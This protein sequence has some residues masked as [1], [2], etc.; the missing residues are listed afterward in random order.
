VNIIIYL[1]LSLSLEAQSKPSY[2]SGKQICSGIQKKQSGQWT[3][4]PKDYN[5]LSK[6]KTS[7]YHRFLG[8][9]FDAS[10]PTIVRVD[11]GPGSTSHNYGP[12]FDELAKDHNIL[13]FDQRGYVCSRPDQESDQGDINFYGIEKSARDIE[14]IRKA[15]GIKKLIVYGESFGATISTQYAALFPESTQNVILEGPAFLIPENKLL[16]EEFSKDVLEKSSSLLE[17]KVQF[18]LKDQEYQSMIMTFGDTAGISGINQITK[19]LNEKYRKTKR[20]VT[21]E[22]ADQMIV[23]N[24]KKWKHGSFSLK[25]EAFTWEKNNTELIVEKDL[26]CSFLS[27]VGCDE[28]SEKKK[29]TFDVNKLLINVPVSIFHGSLDRTPIKEV[30]MSQKNMSNS[31]LIEIVGHGHGVFGTS[32]SLLQKE[33]N[34]ALIRKALQGYKITEDDI[35][36]FNEK[37]GS[38]AIKH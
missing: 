24:F 37:A 7:I 22:E 5:D 38:Q 12:W 4:V 33:K 35:K 2:K 23:K 29:N 19:A 17:P 13:F 16:K 32:E 27:D 20:L 21:W 34:M 28:G 25:D 15:L 6:G 3:P 31:Q 36:I 14:E 11:G 10:K 9:K 1:L 26:G 18:C 8:G 30:S